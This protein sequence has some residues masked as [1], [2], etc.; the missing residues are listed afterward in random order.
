ML[1]YLYALATGEKKGIIADLLRAILFLLSLVY[2]IAVRILIKCHSLFS[3]RLDCKVVSV[4]NITLGGTGKTSF[5]EY[6]ARYLLEQDL[7]P[8]ILSRGY[9]KDGAYLQGLGDE[10]YMLKARLKDVPV[11]VDTDRING[12]R[13]AIVDHGVDTVILDDGFQQWKIRKDLEI[14]MIDAAFSFAGSYMLPRGFLREPLS[15]LKRADI[16]VLAKTNLYPDT[17][18]L[19]RY[20]RLNNPRA[21]IVKSEHQPVGLYAL[22]DHNRVFTVD[23]IKDKSVV[24][25][26]GIADPSS[27]DNLMHE[28]G[29]HILHSF[30]FPDHHYYS[31]AELNGIFQTAR[32]AH[33]DMVVTTEKD[34]ARIA[35]VKADDMAVFVLRIELKVTHNE[36]E[37]RSRLHKLY[38]P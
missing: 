17:D 11:I 7:H 36:N 35:G 26:S 38:L 23:H 1:K 25:F 29:A 27:F 13:R 30:Q 22:D 16:F 24:L 12:A 28:L 37:L 5:V 8:A 4:G 19:E 31:D 6:L 10:P 18:N 2:G 14:V 34:A 3:C 32:K 20:L 9:K 21:L 15:S 33:S